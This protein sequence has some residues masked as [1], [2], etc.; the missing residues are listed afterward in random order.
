M[1]RL[2][3]GF[4]IALALFAALLLLSHR[5]H[6]TG[7]Q[8][9]PSTGVDD[10]TLVVA[11]SSDMESLEPNSLNS[12]SSVNVAA[13]LW[14]TLLHVTPQGQLIPA[15]A[16]GYTW[17]DAGT[18]ITFDIKPGLRCQD[19]SHLTAT[20]VVYSF[21]RAADPKFGFYGNLPAF[22]YS[23][24]GFLGARQT[25][26][27]KATIRVRAYSSQ[28]PGMLAEGYIVCKNA[29]EHLPA[30]VAAEH[31]VSTGPYRLVEWSRDDRIVLERNPSYT[32]ARG[33]FARVIF[34][35]I[36]EASTRAAELIAGGVDLISNVSPDQS[37]SIN[38]SGTA[39]VKAVQ[40]TRRMFVGYNLAPSFAAT[41]GGAA[42]QKKA[43]RQALEYAIDVPM[44]CAELLRMP[45]QRMSSPVEFEHSHVQ[46]YPYDPDK[47]EALLDTAGYRR[48]PDGVRFHLTLQGP[49]NRYLEDVNVTQAVA[50]FLSDIGVQTTVE[51]MD[52]ITVFGPRSR[53]HEV[54]P[55]FFM[56]NGGATWSSIFEM[57]LFPD[58]MANTNTG[59]WFN[60][61]WQ[62]GLKA[63]ENVR[64]PGREK[65]II[66][67]MLN[68][69]RDDA[70]WLFLY[71]Q[72]DFYGIGKR[73]E[74]APRRDELIDVMA[75][76]PHWEP[77]PPSP[78]QR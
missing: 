18:E 16:S 27:L 7:S 3:S 29:Y 25:G 13:L 24:I 59:E 72:P 56:G 78:D 20:D 22:V 31:P 15:M 51:S 33:P 39:V 40:G 77:H 66:D 10:R 71:F 12:A 30:A 52:F 45:C 75:I 46:P 58:K 32:L 14:G 23:A 44:I 17:N 61:E 2:A 64:E 26:D 74:W 73:I 55:I 36:P 50:Q 47:A 5:H 21:N 70:P 34:R 8:E 57:S 54:G 76:R 49:R 9:A 65:E 35:V 38:E 48:G 43:V 1:R 69:F 28:V 6:R 68:V 42:L 53:R 11:Q 37:D 67:H 60:P 41:P 4:S 63:L 62:A 19:G